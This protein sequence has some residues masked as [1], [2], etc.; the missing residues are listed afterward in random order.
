[1]AKRQSVLKS[2]IFAVDSNSKL[3]IQRTIEGEVKWFQFQ[4]ETTIKIISFDFIILLVKSMCVPHH[5][6][7]EKKICFGT[8]VNKQNHYYYYYC[9]FTLALEK[10]FSDTSF[11][12]PHIPVCANSCLNIYADDICLH[13]LDAMLFDMWRK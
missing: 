8:C 9:Q 6:E 11:P 7:V 2:H 13:L 4:V 5:Y 10:L 3:S 12:T 1:M